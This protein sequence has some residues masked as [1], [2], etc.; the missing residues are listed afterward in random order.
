[1]A[2]HSVLWGTVDRGLP[3]PISSMPACVPGLCEE[4]TYVADTAGT[5][6]TMYAN[7]RVCYL[8]GAIPVIYG[9]IIFFA[10]HET[11]HWY[12][13][14]G[15]L[16]KACE[17]LTQIEQAT[18]HTSHAYDPNL[19]IVPPK[20]EKVGPA[21][22]FSS[23]YIVATAAIWT[24]YFIGQ[25]CV[26]GMNT[27]LPSWFTGIGYSA[28]D[29]VTLQTLNNVGAILSNI[30]VGFVSAGAQKAKNGKQA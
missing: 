25:F 23:K 21:I 27:W 9:V 12:A 2:A 14:N 5:T 24:A 22:L 28:T 29:A 18:R 13:N 19:L 10:M 20:P 15:Q 16:D 7:W 8:I 30:S 26:F 6:A 17:R 11:P 3:S 4:I 1:M